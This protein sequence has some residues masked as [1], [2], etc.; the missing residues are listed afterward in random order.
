MCDFWEAFVRGVM[1]VLLISLLYVGC[2]GQK[3][4]NNMFLGLEKDVNMV[5]Q[6]INKKENTER[7]PTEEKREDKKEQSTEEKKEDIEDYDFNGTDSHVLIPS[8][9]F[10][11]GMPN[12]FSIIG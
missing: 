2:I 3:K 11:T 8:I 7:Q 10:N 5:E 9:D 12:G 1:V 4:I 6:S